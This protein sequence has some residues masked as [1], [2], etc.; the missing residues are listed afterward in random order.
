M[1]KSTVTD[2]WVSTPENTVI[3]GEICAK[4]TAPRK[5]SG[6]N[7]QTDYSELEVAEF[8][9]RINEMLRI[10]FVRVPNISVGDHVYF[11]KPSS[12][13]KAGEYEVI[14]IKTGYRNPKLV[15]NPT[16]VDIRKVTE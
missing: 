9:G 11:A 10:R 13:D 12:D 3:S 16:I 4:Y 6:A 1:R 7:I 14:S 5:I 2:I 15:R 8:G